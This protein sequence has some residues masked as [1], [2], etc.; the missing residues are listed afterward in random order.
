MQKLALQDLILIA[1]GFSA[2]YPAGSLLP[3]L[4]SPRFRSK[5]C[6]ILMD[7]HYTLKIEVKVLQHFDGDQ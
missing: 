6:N 2:D 7:T 3:H 4:L 5:V 1:G